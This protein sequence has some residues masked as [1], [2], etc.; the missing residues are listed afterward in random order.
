[1]IDKRKKPCLGGNL[2]LQSEVEELDL[3]ISGIRT[4]LGEETLFS[5]LGFSMVN[6][7]CDLM[8]KK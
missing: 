2:I 3:T 6:L 5:D 4:N 7:H 8:D 1:M